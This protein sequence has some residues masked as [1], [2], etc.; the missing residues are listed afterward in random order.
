MGNYDEVYQRLTPEQRELVDGIETAQAIHERKLKKC[1]YNFLY[2]H[3]RGGLKVQTLVEYLQRRF[4]RET[5]DHL[6]RVINDAVCSMK[7]RG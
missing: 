1:A 4:P 7:Y 5:E 2:R 6:K 3:R